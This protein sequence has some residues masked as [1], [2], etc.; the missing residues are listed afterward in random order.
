[1]GTCHQT[2]IP[3]PPRLMIAAPQGR[4]GKTTI[5]IALARALR[6]RGLSVQPFKKGPDYI[7]PSWLRLASGRDCSNLDGF[8][9][10]ED[11]LLS[12]FARRSRGAD[13]AI[14]EGAM[15]LFDSPEA[16]GKGSV[17]WLARM[18]QAPIILV[19]NTERMTRS[20]AALVSGFQHFEPGTDLA[21]VILNHVSGARHEKKLRD[22]VE[23]HCGIPVLGAVPRHPALS[24]AERHLGLIPSGEKDQ[25]E[26]I[27][28]TI[29]D[30]V[31]THLNID[32]IVAIARQ[33]PEQQISDLP[34]IPAIK[35]TCRI[36]VIADRAF[37]FYYPENLEA[38]REAGADIVLI[39]ALSDRALPEIDGLYIGGGFP[40]LYAAELE[41]NK[42]LRHDLARRIENGL[43]T[44]A[45][46]AGLMYLSRAIRWQERR[47]EMVGVVPADVEVSKR[48]Q[49]HGYVEIEVAADNPWFP[50]GSVLHGHEFHHSRLIAEGP[51]H[52][53]A[54]RT[55]RGHGI[56][57]SVD[58]FFY[59]NLFASYTHLHALGVPQ[60]APAFVALA[61]EYKCRAEA[62]VEVEEMASEKQETEKN[63][64]LLRIGTRKLSVD[65][66]QP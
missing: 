8:L 29:C 66:T 30:K 10:P 18:L 22:A 55:L 4:S 54:C 15:G 47:Y 56:D 23:R 5:A 45:E 16:D 9:M 35:P 26:S 40:E 50:T 19:V 39:D 58:G 52:A 42:R 12:S 2:L 51:P 41:A 20:V 63:N 48:P 13:M 7:D 46:C 21:G 62:K 53:T 64:E 60:W 14:V 34:R 38:L 31:A 6:N 1:V 65:F 32:A 36:G 57:G 37:S 17:A 44:Y 61:K 27:V 43:P 59:K 11:V 24:I 49:G 28:E 3:A 33:A 25:A